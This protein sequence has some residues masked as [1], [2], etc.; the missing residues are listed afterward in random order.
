M[1][2]LGFQNQVGAHEGLTRIKINILKLQKLNYINSFTNRI[3]RKLYKLQLPTILYNSLCIILCKVKNYLTSS[4][5]LLASSN[6]LKPSTFCSISS[7]SS[8]LHSSALDD[9][10]I[11]SCWKICGFFKKYFLF[12][13]HITSISDA[14]FHSIEQKN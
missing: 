7:I 2:L 3:Y 5:F 10:S 4:S 9:S 6:S 8:S 14:N 1:I 11:S 13:V 12:C